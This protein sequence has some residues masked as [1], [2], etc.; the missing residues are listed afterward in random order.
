VGK[1][2]P[3]NGNSDGIN[4]YY[5]DADEIFGLA[6]GLSGPDG[7]FLCRNGKCLGYGV[8]AGLVYFNRS[9]DAVGAITAALSGYACVAIDVDGYNYVIGTN[10]IVIYDDYLNVLDTVT[11]SFVTLNPGTARADVADGYLW[12]LSSWIGTLYRMDISTRAIEIFGVIPS[13][14]V[15]HY[16]SAEFRVI[17][18]TLIQA[19]PNS[20]NSSLNVRALRFYSLT[21]A[22]TTLGNIVESECLKSELLTAGDLDVTE[23]TDSV[24]G[25]RIASLGAL[26]GGIEPLRAAWPFDVVQHGYQIKFKRRGSASVATIDADELDA[27]AAGETPGVQI[28][29]SREM[30]TLLPSSL[31][32]NY[33]DSLREYETNGQISDRGL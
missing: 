4:D 5:L 3:P 23:L 16:Y 2:V 18:G 25:Y 29:N 9:Q 27:R 13:W 1:D 32:L 19:A 26:R 31:R 11:Y 21:P 28:T 10:G 6:A 14:S 30:D 24:R 22:G 33:I 7:S 17:N 20:T 8:G 15:N 12:I